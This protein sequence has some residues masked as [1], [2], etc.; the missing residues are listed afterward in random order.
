M[1]YREMIIKMKTSIK[2]CFVMS[3][4]TGLSLVLL[5]K[6]INTFYVSCPTFKGNCLV[7]ASVFSWPINGNYP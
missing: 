4:T 6:N 3:L 7:Q 2:V 1:S 5:E